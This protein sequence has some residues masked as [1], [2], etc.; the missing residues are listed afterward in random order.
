MVLAE[1]I[2]SHLV[3]RLRSDFSIYPALEGGTSKGKQSPLYNG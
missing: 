2:E 3:K 1:C